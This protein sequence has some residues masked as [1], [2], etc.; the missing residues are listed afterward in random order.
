VKVFNRWQLEQRAVNMVKRCIMNHSARLTSLTI[1]GAGAASA[2]TYFIVI[3]PWLRSW[4]EV[5]DEGPLP[6]DAIVPRPRY[7]ATRAVTIAAPAAEIWPWLVQIGQGRGG[8]YSYDWLEN[9]IGCDIHSAD[10]ILPEYQHVSAGDPVRLAP[11]GKSKLPPLTVA[12][13][14]PDRALVL[15]TPG[16][17]EENFALGAPFATWAFILEP[18]DEENAKLIARWRADYIPTLRGKLANH[19]LLQP[20]HFIM[21]RKMLLGIKKRA[22]ATEAKAQPTSATLAS[23]ATTSVAR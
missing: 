10:R 2:A 23:L 15:L 16:T 21:E 14:E 12:V 5:N 9:L 7:V 13:I 18:I 22:E 11:E 4:E 6:G 3:R 8:F 17:P 19:Y 20:I 1:L